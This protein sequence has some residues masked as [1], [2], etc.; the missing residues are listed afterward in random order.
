[1]IICTYV[2]IRNDSCIIPRKLSKQITSPDLRTDRSCT[3][4][5]DDNMRKV[6]SETLRLLL[7]SHPFD[8][9]QSVLESDLDN[10]TTRYR[11]VRTGDVATMQITR[12]VQNMDTFFQNQKVIHKKTKQISEK[13]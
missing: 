5:H 8:R 6:L 11:L 12:A 7:H 10:R 3:A 9:S 2:T 13:K 1:M 4:S